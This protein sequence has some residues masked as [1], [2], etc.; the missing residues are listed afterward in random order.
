MGEP[1]S[2]PC[3]KLQHWYFAAVACVTFAV[4]AQQPLYHSDL[5][6][7]L[8][9]GRL[10]WSERQLPT[11]EPFMPLAS[12]VPMKATAW[13]SQIAGFLTWSAGNTA[14]L[15]LLHGFLIAMIVWLLQR[16]IFL[17]TQSQIS[18]SVG[19][20]TFLIMARDQICILRP[21]L[22]GV[23]CFVCL[24]VQMTRSKRRPNYLATGLLF[25]FWANSHPSFPAGL[26]LLSLILMGRSI[27]AYRE[28]G[29]VQAAL[30]SAEVRRTFL[31]L[32]AATICAVANPYG[33]TLFLEVLNVSSNPNL[34]DLL[35]W[36]PLSLATRQGQVAT[37][38]AAI[39]SIILLVRRQRLTTAELLAFVVTGMAA[40]VSSRMIN[41]WAPI[42]SLIVAI[43][44]KPPMDAKPLGV[45]QHLSVGVMTVAVLLGIV[46]QRSL[47]SPDHFSHETPLELATPALKSANGNT[48]WAPNT[49]ADYLVWIANGEANVF[50]TSHV[51][52]IP[53]NVWHDYR[54]ISTGSEH[55]LN[56]LDA[57]NVATVLVGRR[58]RALIDL[59]ADSEDW[60]LIERTKRG[61]LFER[62]KE[63][64]T[65]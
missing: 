58:R 31:L 53:I 21:Q 49:W 11:T 2:P 48:I 16:S 62:I 20:I 42:T 30:K 36:K 32:V 15:R 1:A 65:E 7:H 13:L 4:Y 43:G 56:A 28:A 47:T 25:T 12:D 51:H 22:V 41:W 5:W 55:A 19:V 50:A 6:G 60:T 45:S 9:Y 26:I 52:L 3:H 61:H 8:S 33:P 18:S 23:A 38:V 34:R 64:R 10:I 24:T 46:G 17:R 63:G 14:G 37:A 40:F 27:D 54:R 29:T 44:C 35:D 59:L 57:H 39:A